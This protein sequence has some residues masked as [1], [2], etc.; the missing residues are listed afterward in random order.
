MTIYN[1]KHKYDT[2]IK[3]HTM[4]YEKGTQKKKDRKKYFY[5]RRIREGLMEI[6]EFLLDLDKEVGF[7]WAE[8][9][10]NSRLE[11]RINSNLQKCLQVMPIGSPTILLIRG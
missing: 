6:L 1:P 9:Q 7:Q 5:L 3:I 8:M 11:P 10:Q 2:L 4:W